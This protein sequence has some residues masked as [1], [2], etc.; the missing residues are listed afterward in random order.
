[1]GT[2]QTHQPYKG[3]GEVRPM[4]KSIA[5]SLVFLLGVWAGTTLT[6]LTQADRLLDKT[7]YEA[8]QESRM[9]LEITE[10]ACGQLQD[11]YGREYICTQANMSRDNHCWVERN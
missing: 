10:Q 6:W 9:S 4:K 5:I 11:M 3:M 2:I 7:V 1:M 8:C